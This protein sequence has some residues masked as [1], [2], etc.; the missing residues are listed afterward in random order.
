MTGLT[1]FNKINPG[2]CRANRANFCLASK[3]STTQEPFHELCI[4]QIWDSSEVSKLLQQLN[5]TYQ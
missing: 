2:K 4:S 1:G 3:K 5:P